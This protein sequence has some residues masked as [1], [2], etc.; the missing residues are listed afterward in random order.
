M[1]QN[2]YNEVIEAFKDY[3]KNISIEKILKNMD[4]I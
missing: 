3:V 1:S 2:N 4:E